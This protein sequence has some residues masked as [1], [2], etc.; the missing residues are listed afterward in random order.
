MSKRLSRKGVVTLQ[1]EKARPCCRHASVRRISPARRGLTCSIVRLFVPVPLIKRH[2]CQLHHCLIQGSYKEYVAAFVA[3]IHKV[4]QG[5][6]GIVRVVADD[7]KLHPIGHELLQYLA[8]HP[9]GQHK[10]VLAEGGFVYR[11]IG[12]MMGIADGRHQ[13]KRGLRIN[14]KR[15]L[16]LNDG[17]AADD[18]GLHGIIPSS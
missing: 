5:F 18:I 14:N 17:D 4:P 7:G 9:C 12:D 2:S 10:K 8:C 16:A 11:D 6:A 13:V 3:L 15:A 1:A